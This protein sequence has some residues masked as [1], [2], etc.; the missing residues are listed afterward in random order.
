MTKEQ[1]MTVLEEHNQTHVMRGFDDLTSAQQETLLNQIADLQWDDIALAGNQTEIP[2]GEITPIE[3]MDV[4]EIDAKREEYAKIGYEAIK[5]GK[6]AALLLAGGMG[7]R[8]G[9]D[10]PKGELN[11]GVD[12]TLYIFQCLINNLMDVTNVAG[13][14]VPLYIMTSEKNNDE[15]I[16]FFEEQNYFGYPKE[17]VA[18]FVQEMA[19]AVDYDGKLL[20]EE[21]GRLATSPNGNG[22]WFSSLQKAGLLEDVHKRGVEWINIFAVDNVLQ[23]ICDPTFIGATIESGKVSGSKVVRKVDPYEKMGVMCLEDGKPSVVEYYELSEDMA[24][25]TNPDGKLTYA[26]GVILNYIFRVDKLEEIVEKHLPVHVVEKKIPY[27]TEAGELV[28]P[29][30][31]NGYK[32]ETLVVDMIRLMDDN[33]PFEVVREKEF[34]PI[35]NLHGVDSLDSARELLQANGVEL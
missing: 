14:T 19:A 18:F 29:T 4:D 33:L 17:D 23:R 32:F 5:E 34:A 22:G 1:A 3:G 9:F 6:V 8:L 12:K 16:R 25:A 24:E 21:P 15:T 26:Y 20:M 13:K 2:L 28:K 10:K 11:V 35:K 7:T 31:P 27:I 30:E